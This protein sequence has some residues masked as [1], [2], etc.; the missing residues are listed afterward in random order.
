MGISYLTVQLTTS[1]LPFSEDVHGGHYELH[2]ELSLSDSE[3][4][5]I[6][7]FESDYQNQ[8]TLLLQEFNQRIGTL[9]GLLVNDDEW[10]QNGN[11]WQESFFGKR[12]IK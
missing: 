6:E 10:N 2:K 9:G 11:S 5:A 7:A 12:R 1:P 3:A 4:K 8:R